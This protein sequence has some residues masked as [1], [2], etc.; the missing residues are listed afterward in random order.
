[1][2]DDEDVMLVDDEDCDV[3]EADENEFVSH[4]AHKDVVSKHKRKETVIRRQA[5]DMPS[6]IISKSGA[7]PSSK[8]S[9]K[10]IKKVP[11]KLDEN[12]NFIDSDNEVKKGRKRTHDEAAPSKRKTAP[13]TAPAP[14]NTLLQ[15]L[16][17]NAKKSSTTSAKGVK[18]EP[19]PSH[20][21]ASDE[22]EYNADCVI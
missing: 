20:D 10:A 4:L 22:S 2:L 5:L 3:I 18:N 19:P 12:E 11:L 6:K 15:R 1:M 7:V 17:E 8:T 16:G 9:A 21:H 14:S 13:K